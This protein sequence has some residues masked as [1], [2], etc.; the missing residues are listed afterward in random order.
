MINRLF[1][2]DENQSLHLHVIWRFSLAQAVPGCFIVSSDIR[3]RPRCAGSMCVTRRS[4]AEGLE[5]THESQILTCT[6]C[7][8][9]RTRIVDIDG[10]EL[11]Q[12][13]DQPQ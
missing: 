8:F 13:A 9:D 2:F 3:R 5:Q 10:I 6:S 4:P 7:G 1:R 12:A 11:V